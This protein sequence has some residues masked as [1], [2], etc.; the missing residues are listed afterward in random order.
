MPRPGAGGRGAGAAGPRCRGCQPAHGTRAGRP[1]RAAARWAK[2]DRRDEV[3]GMKDIIVGVDASDTSVDAVRVAAGLAAQ[4][5]AALT[6]V[7]V[8]RAP[9]S[10]VN[11]PMP[12]EDEVEAYVTLL[13]GAVRPGHSPARA[14]RGPSRSGTATLPGSSRR[15]PGSAAPTSSWSAPASRRSGTCRGTGRCR[16]G[17]STTPTGRCW[18]SA[19]GGH[20]CAR[21]SSVSTPPSRPPRPPRSPAGSPGTLPRISRWCTSGTSRSA[22]R[23]RRS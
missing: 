12:G 18:S 11:Q 19:P 6:V 13:R 5:G 14:F 20:W 21:W 17:S 2:V 9:P 23:A 10:W 8:R 16:T 3:G 7:H 1:W 15:R 4:T 22:T